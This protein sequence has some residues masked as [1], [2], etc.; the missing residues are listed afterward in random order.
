MV[1]M[2]AAR[3]RAANKVACSLQSPRRDDSTSTAE[4]RLTVICLARFLLTHR[5]MTKA[6]SQGVFFPEMICRAVVFILGSSDWIRAVDARYFSKLSGRIASSILPFNSDMETICCTLSK[7]FCRPP[8]I[9]ML[10]ISKP[11]ILILRYSISRGLSKAI[12]VT[13]TESWVSRSIPVSSAGICR[14]DS[15]VSRTSVMPSGPFSLRVFPAEST[16]MVLVVPAISR[17]NL[18]AQWDW[19]SI[20]RLSWD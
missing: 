4:G 20:L 3:A 12:P 19:S 9:S 14:A 15:L 16:Q 11:A 17:L 8:A 7:T 5:L 1:G 10:V 6:F 2:P 18:V 13:G